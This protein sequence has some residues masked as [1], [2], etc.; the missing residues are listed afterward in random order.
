MLNEAHTHLVQIIPEIES[1]DNV[2]NRT[3]RIVELQ[4]K[5]VELFKEYYKCTNNNQEPSQELVDLFKEI[6]N[7]KNETD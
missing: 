1:E 7:R 6:I 3:G 2:S 5:P 4:D